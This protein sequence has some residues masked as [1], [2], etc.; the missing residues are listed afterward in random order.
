MEGGLCTLVTTSRLGSVWFDQGWSFFAR[1]KW[2]GDGQVIALPWGW[3][4]GDC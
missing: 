2:C 1:L 3:W 4:L